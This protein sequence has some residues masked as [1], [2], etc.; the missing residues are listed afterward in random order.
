MCIYAF[1]C[2]SLLSRIRF[3]NV[4]HLQ[5]IYALNVFSRTEQVH[6]YGDFCSLHGS[7]YSDFDS[8][9][10]RIGPPP[11]RKYTSSRRFS[12]SGNSDEKLKALKKKKEAKR[13]ERLT[14]QRINELK[15]SVSILCVFSSAI[16]K[17]RHSEVLP[18]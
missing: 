6:V 18:F 13:T 15:R 8:K 1:S 16:P 7:Q 17:G 14:R 11:W 3:C 5:N 10:T 12:S 9:Y 4:S 2:R